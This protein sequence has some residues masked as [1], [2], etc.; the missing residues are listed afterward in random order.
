MKGIY[1]P[2]K[3]KYDEAGEARK[4][5]FADAVAGVNCWELKFPARPTLPTVLAGYTGLRA[6]QHSATKDYTF[7]AGATLPD[8]MT[9]TTGLQANEFVVDGGY[10]GGWG[11][12]TMGLHTIK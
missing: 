10:G 3:T 8:T 9:A 2:L 5:C 11:A 1:D 6:A 4:K 7:A 12:W